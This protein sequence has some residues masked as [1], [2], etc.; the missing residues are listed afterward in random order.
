MWDLPTG[1]ELVDQEAVDRLASTKLAADSQADTAAVFGGGDAVRVEGGQ[2][3]DHVIYVL[4]PYQA[5][6][7]LCRASKQHRTA[8]V[9]EW[10]ATQLLFYSLSGSGST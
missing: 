7:R 3:F 10:G 9:G 6:P 8:V 1:V 5:N 4:P 2:G